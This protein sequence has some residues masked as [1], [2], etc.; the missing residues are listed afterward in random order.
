MR[1]SGCAMVW[2]RIRTTPMTIVRRHEN[3]PPSATPAIRLRVVC[4]WTDAVGAV[5]RTHGKHMSADGRGS[6]PKPR[7]AR[8]R[9]ASALMR[10]HQRTTYP[11]T[12]DRQSLYPLMSPGGPLVMSPDNRDED[13]G[14]AHRA[15]RPGDDVDGAAGKVDEQLVASDMGLA[16]RRLQPTRPFPIKVAEPTVAVA[17]GSLGSILFPEQRQGDI[18]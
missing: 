11:R 8:G 13:G 2:G 16:H 7:T 18:G 5:R 1:R 10:V 17:L 6:R 14:A 4:R 15:G 12:S 3:G 9:A